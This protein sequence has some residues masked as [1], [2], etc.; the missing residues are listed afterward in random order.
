MEGESRQSS[1][2]LESQENRRGASSLWR[3]FRAYIGARM[4]PKGGT[5]CETRGSI[6]HKFHIGHTDL[7]NADH[8]PA[9]GS[10]YL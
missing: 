1:G 9:D 5:V 8:G 2:H 7:W 3:P 4:Y 10:F 6:S